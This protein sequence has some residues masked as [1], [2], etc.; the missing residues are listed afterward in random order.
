MPT[1]SLMVPDGGPPSD[2]QAGSPPGGPSSP[3][4]T[5]AQLSLH[6]LPY[7]LV[8]QPP[9]APLDTLEKVYFQALWL[10]EAH[11]P[12]T[13]FLATL[14]RVHASHA[15]ALLPLARTPAQLSE[16]YQRHVRDALPALLGV[17]RRTRADAPPLC[18]GE[19][20]A[21]SAALALGPIAS[22]LPEDGAEA[23]LR[24]ATRPLLVAVHS[25][26]YVFQV[27]APL[28]AGCNCS[29]SSY[30][31]SYASAPSTPRPLRRGRRRPHRRQRGQ[32]L[33][34]RRRRPAGGRVRR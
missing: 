15:D 33:S 22:A 9:L 24:R 27:E 23:E 3:P 20:Q 18:A 30:F 1:D 12:L 16:K 4:G 10:G 11:T 19:A 5:S 17:A 25:R 14:D 28:T 29:C 32:S 21:A 6:P 31:G 2:A 13:Y 7:S 26:E 8:A 34:A